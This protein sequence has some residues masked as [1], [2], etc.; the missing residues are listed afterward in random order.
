M[1]DRER[2]VVPACH[3]GAG[4]GPRVTTHPSWN[5]VKQILEA[6]LDRPPVE[7]AEFVVRTCGDDPSLRG[8]VESLLA[9]IGQAGTFIEPPPALVLKPGDSLDSYQV[10]EFL[11]AGG[12]GE[13]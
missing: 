1:A 2:M 8:E 13:V 3:D 11:G 4:G 5:R 6:A 7:R 9:A 12:M 10:L